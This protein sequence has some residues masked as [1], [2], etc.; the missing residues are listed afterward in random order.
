MIDVQL[1]LGL[2]RCKVAVLIIL[3]VASTEFD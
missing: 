3:G 1:I 2:D